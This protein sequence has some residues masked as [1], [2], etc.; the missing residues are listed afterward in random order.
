MLQTLRARRGMVVAPHHLAAQAGR[1]VLCDG[2][3]AVEA[4]VATAAC[5]AVVYPHMTGI[6]GDG[7][8]LIHEPDGRVHAIDACGRAA[9]AATRAFY[10]GHTSIPWRGPGAANTVAG[11]VSGWAL[12]LQHAGGSLPLPRVLRDAIVHAHAGVPVTLGGAQIAADKG[13][14]LRAQPGAYA[15]I[16]EPHGAPLREGELLT[17]RQLA[18]TLHRLA[19]DGLDSFYRGAL[20]ADIAADL[21]A[22]GSPLRAHDL[23][24]H[25]AEASVPLS[26]ALHGARVYNHAP[27]TQGLAS[28]LILALFE[29]LHADDADSFAHLHGLVEA[30]K[31]AFLIRDAHVGDPAWMTLDAQALLDDAQALDGLAAR[32]DMARAMPWPQPSQAGDTVWFGAIDAAGRAV[33]CIQSTYFEFGSGLVLPRTGITWQNRG[34]SFRLADDGWNALAPGRKPFHTLNPAMA[35]FDDGRVMAYGT[36]GGEGQPQTQ[37]AIFSRYARYGMPLQQAVTAPRWLLGRTW[38]QD[39]TSLKLED[40]FDPALVQALRAAGHAVELLPAFTSVM[41]HAGA[42][43]RGA[44]GTI[45][46]ASDPRSDGAAAGW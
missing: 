28:L 11:T 5:L 19:E 14:E 4:A 1:D 43:V 20:A 32:I 26:V 2:G 15:E 45:S 10:R 40:R 33:S 12:A 44:D 23:A 30:T 36:M 7:F 27:P 22:L 17:Q 9:Q 42:L 34:C 41:G 13:V 38:G 37:A 21:H 39:S 25:R 6:G 46:A 24:Q 35:V 3:T 8:W 31:Q 18:T 29:R 16:F